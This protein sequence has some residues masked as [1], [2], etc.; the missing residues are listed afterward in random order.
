MG[1]Q[2]SSKIPCAN[3]STDDLSEAS[4]LG[5]AIAQ[6][7]S[8]QQFTLQTLH[9]KTGISIG[10]LSG[11]ECGKKQNISN[12]IIFKLAAALNL[13][14]DYLFLL[15]GRLPLRHVAIAQ[16]SPEVVLC[17]LQGVG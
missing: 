13:S 5:R 1:I 16:H 11:I 4:P 7:R 10:Y 17:A 9:E 12:E 3:F 14:A 2:N 8:E 15:A 6:A